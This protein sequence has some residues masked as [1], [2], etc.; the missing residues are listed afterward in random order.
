MVWARWARAILRRDL[1]IKL[2][3]ALVCARAKLSRRSGTGQDRTGQERDRSWTGQDWTGQDM[4]WTAATTG[5]YSRFYYLPLDFH[6]KSSILLRCQPKHTYSL[7][8]LHNRNRLH[9][10]RYY[11]ACSIAL[12]YLPCSLIYLPCSL[13]RSPLRLSHCWWSVS[14]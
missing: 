5:D 13:S 3:A 7:S 6:Q 8:R 1:R 14:I 9:A 11:R 12:I 10:A 2:G 4:G